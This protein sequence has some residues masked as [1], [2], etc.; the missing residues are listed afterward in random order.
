MQFIF[1]QAHRAPRG[2]WAWQMVPSKIGSWQPAQPCH[3]R[4]IPNVRLSLPGKSSWHRTTN[5]ESTNPKKFHENECVDFERVN[6]VFFE[7]KCYIGILLS[8]LIRSFSK[9]KQRTCSWHQTTN[10]AVH[11]FEVLQN[12]FK[13]KKQG[14]T[15]FL[16]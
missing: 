6:I 7:K 5:P 15:C 9:S 8:I 12:V 10:Y 11:E 16:K 1:L 3:V 13:M 4:T 14:L 2:L